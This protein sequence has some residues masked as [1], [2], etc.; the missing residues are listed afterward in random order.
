MQRFSSEALCWATKRILGQHERWHLAREQ[1]SAQARHEA[2][3][4]AVLFV[5]EVI[6]IVG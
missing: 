2:N 3:V 5:M 6:N 1:L 4:D